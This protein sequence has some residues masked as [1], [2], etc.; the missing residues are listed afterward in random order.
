MLIIDVLKNLSIEKPAW[1]L[2]LSNNRGSEF[3]TLEGIPYTDIDE[4]KEFQID[5][6]INMSEQALF[7]MSLR[8]LRYIINIKILP[9]LK[10]KQN[11]EPSDY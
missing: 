4:T 1:S 8:Y 11:I 5:V 7:L 2:E 6:K 10:L 9:D 3:F